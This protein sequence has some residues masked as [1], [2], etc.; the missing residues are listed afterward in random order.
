MSDL[1]THCKISL[2]RTKGKNDYKELHQ[3]MDEP[4]SMFGN[5]HRL[6]RHSLNDVYLKYVLDNWGEKGVVEWLFHIAID[7]LETAT[8]RAHSCYKSEYSSYNIELKGGKI[9]SIKGIKNG[10]DNKE[11]K[12]V[13]EDKPKKKFIPYGKFKKH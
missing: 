13:K 3:W 2:E 6:E 4:K 1:K 10:S 11:K 9:D 8:K 7:N 12:P 5:N